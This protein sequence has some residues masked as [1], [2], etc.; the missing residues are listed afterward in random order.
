[1]AVLRNCHL[2]GNYFWKNHPLCQWR[3]SSQSAMFTFASHLITLHLK[4]L[5]V[6]VPLNVLDIPSELWEIFRGP[7]CLYNMSFFSANTCR[8]YSKMD[9][10]F[11]GPSQMRI[12]DSIENDSSYMWLS[13]V[14]ISR[15]TFIRFFLAVFYKNALST[16][17]LENLVAAWSKTPR[18]V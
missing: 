17:G 18:F 5:S 14:A 6:L 12:C 10:F 16:F 15:A 2:P 8:K 1:M 13:D 11:H 9:C 4:L 7:K 3:Q